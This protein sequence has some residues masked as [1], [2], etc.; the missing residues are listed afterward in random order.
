MKHWIVSIALVLVNCL[1]HIDPLLAQ[2]V[3][4]RDV[5]IVY[6]N[7]GKLHVEPSAA[8]LIAYSAIN[9]LNEETGAN[10]VLSRFR[11]T[12]DRCPNARRA[13]ISTPIF[14]CWWRYVERRHYNRN[15]TLVISPPKW[16]FFGT[17]LVLW[18]VARGICA[19]PRKRLAVS[20]AEMV[21]QDGTPRLQH[22]IAG[23]AHELGHL[24]GA[25]HQ[26]GPN[27]MNPGALSFVDQ[28]LPEPLPILDVTKNEIY[29]CLN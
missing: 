11:M 9:R 16:D 14:W 19:P 26:E 25:Y 2:S 13:G 5:T 8:K 23:A 27:L 18:G 21:N 20:G 17:Q 24:L 4:S 3:V 22:S 12:K 28:F 29:E 15:Y 7:T 10:L 1:L 6:A